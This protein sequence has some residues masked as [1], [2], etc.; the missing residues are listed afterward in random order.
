MRFRFGSLIFLGVMLLIDLYVF[1]AVRVATVHSAHRTRSIIYILYGLACLAGLLLVAFFP[2]LHYDRWPK[3]LRTVVFALIIG[4]FLSELV[5]VIFLLADDLRRAVQWGLRGIAGVIRPHPPGQ[6]VEGIGRSQFLTRLGLL[7]GGTLYATL[8]YGF[9]NKY[10]YRIHRVRLSFPNLPPAF[11]GLKVLQI[12][13]IHSGSFSNREKVSRGVDMALAEQPDIIFFTGDL[14]N[15]RADEMKDYREVF[16]RLKAPLGVYST[17]GNHDYGDYSWWESRAAKAQNLERLKQIEEEMGWRLL[18]NEHVIVEKEGQRIAVLGVENWS[19]HKRF[20]K[21]GDL[22]KA[23][24]GSEN[25]PFKILLSHDPSHWDAQV[26]PDYPD[27]DLMLSG[28]T[29]GMQFGIEIPGIK[30]SPVQYSYRQW[31]GLYQEGRQCLYVNR[32]YG[33]LGYPGRVGI[34]PEITVFELTSSAQS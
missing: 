22:R 29:H 24:T 4:F 30:W 1:Q 33:F 21:H 9:S 26:R 27:I 32:G 17:L 15:D 20:P 34:L 18:M 5:V 3:T 11:E 8:I 16:S 14:V 23:Y 13:D 6:P 31:A 7:L 10:N 12:S 2:F 28:H 25:I 19:A